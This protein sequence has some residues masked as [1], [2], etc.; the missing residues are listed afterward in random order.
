MME[1]LQIP[2]CRLGLLQAFPSGLVGSKLWSLARDLSGVF[3]PGHGSHI[4]VGEMLESLMTMGQMCWTPA[5]VGQLSNHKTVGVAHVLVALTSPP[6]LPCCHTT[7]GGNRRFTGHCAHHAPDSDYSTA[8]IRGRQ[9]TWL[10]WGC[11]MVGRKKT[12]G[13]L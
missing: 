10:G 11:S 8:A 7:C 1:S 4:I 9:R 12:K 2:Q 6:H 5:W 13:R 3:M